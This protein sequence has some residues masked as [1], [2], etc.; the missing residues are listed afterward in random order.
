MP[1]RP[2]RDLAAHWQL[3]SS[4]DLLKALNTE[5]IPQPSKTGLRPN[6]RLK[7]MDLTGLAIGLAVAQAITAQHPHYVYS[8]S[9]AHHVR[10]VNVAHAAPVSMTAASNFYWVVLASRPDLD[11]AIAVA[12]TQRN[13]NPV[14][15]RSTNGWFAVASGPVYMATG[16][17]RQFLD[18]LISEKHAPQDAFLSRGDR[19][20]QTVW[21]TAS[22][23]APTAS[24]ARTFE[25]VASTP[26]PT[27][28]TQALQ[29]DPQL[30]SQSAAP[31][32]C[33][34]ISESS[35]RLQ[36]YDKANGERSPMPV[37]AANSQ[38]PTVSYA[39]PNPEAPAAAQAI[40]AQVTSVSRASSSEET[41]ISAV[42]ESRDAY[43]AAQNDMAKGGTRSARKAAICAAMSSL[44][45]KGW[46]GKISELSSN[47]D[48]KGVVGITI[49]DG[50]QI[51]TWNNSL[52][53]IEDYTLINP[54]TGLFRRLS[55]MKVGDNV[56]FSGSFV[57][58][59]IDCVKEASFTLS[60][61]MLEPEFIFRFSDITQ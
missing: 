9:P 12:E 22:A 47:G 25:A 27:V 30:V 54:T 36:C 44:S 35:A 10:R 50:V 33:G 21:T 49:A 29:G 59:E 28:S 4:G 53:D 40:S 57:V 56:S 1:P 8:T 2:W 3:K 32:G 37:V 42:T 55:A 26:A 34:S 24:N 15:M 23:N 61:S 17:G 60:G 43:R 16:T 20:I 46:T 58:N 11:Q 48:G 41:F 45:V 31:A 5:A 18:A 39:P 6:E 13:L 38:S 7:K 51:K 52:S 19:F 14:I